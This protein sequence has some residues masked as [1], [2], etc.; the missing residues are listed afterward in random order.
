MGLTAGTKLG[1]YE[2][3]QAVGA[4]GFGQVYKARDT[5]LDRFVAIKVLPEHL[6]QNPTLKA[7][8][9]REAKTLA[10]LSHARICPIFDFG[11]QDGVDY[12]VMEFLE[13][14]TLAERVQRGALPLQEGLKIAID[15]ADAL[16]AAHQAGI[17]HRDLKPGNVM[18][19]KAGPKLLDFGLAKQSAAA[20]FGVQ[21][22][23]PT[24]APA[25]TGE[26]T[27]LG[28]L[29]YMA[30]EQLEG[31]E[32]DGRTDIFAFGAVVYEMLTGKKAFEAKSQVSLIAAILDRDPA[33]I[34]GL[35]PM[36]PAVL[37]HLISG[38]LAKDPADRWQ[39]AHDVL[40]Q[41]KWISEAGASTV[42]GSPNTLGQ[43]RLWITVTAI[44]GV[45]AIVVASL[46][47]AF[48]TAPEMSAARFTVA[49]PEHVKHLMSP[50]GAF[51]GAIS[52]DGR[53]LVFEG[54][55]VDTDKV[56]LYLR[57]IDSIQTMPLQGTE[58]GAYPFW[59][60][61]SHTIAFYAQGKLKRVDLSGGA[62]QIICDAPTGGWGGSWNRDDVILAGLNDPAPIS[63]VSAKGGES[64]LIGSLNSEVDQD[65][66]HF[67]PDGKHFVYAAW[68][69][70]L[71]GVESAQSDN[72]AYVGSLD[73]QDRKLVVKGNTSDVLYADPGYLIFINR[74]RTLVAQPFDAKRLEMT[75]EPIRLAENASG[76]LSVSTN[77]VLTYMTSSTTVP[78]QFVWI[79]RDGTPLGPVLEAGYYAD[80]QISPDGSR[81]AFAKKESASNTFDIWILDLTTG[82]QRRL[83]FDP[84]DDRSPVWSPDG[85]AIIFSSDRKGG[86]GLYRKNSNGVGDEELVSPKEQYS[87]LA[88]QWLPDGRSVIFR[89]GTSAI[90]LW[91]L[92]LTDRKSSP[93]IRTPW[94]NLH[95]VVSPDGK[96]LAYDSRDTN[97]FE[98]YVTTFPP[99]NS[100]WMVTTNGG[101]EP[102]WSKDGKELFYVN[103]SGSL[104]SVEVKVGNPPEFGVHRRIYGGRLDWGF[105]SA[106]SFDIDPKQDRFLVETL[107]VQYEITVVLNWH[108]LLKK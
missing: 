48:R 73:S 4:G 99:T 21:P 25:L 58:G 16:S 93:L 86:V 24:I 46:A 14:Q 92:N 89:G 55:D 78:D 97:R 31:K 26:G 104:M 102:R 66:P 27:I 57:S 6:S 42:Q 33:P 10:S 23:A 36:T 22:D 52:P 15:I 32:A 50:G 91:M 39:T 63:K 80:P 7:R 69:A 51:G 94:N 56:M 1:P 45:A 75:G 106:H 95:G 88:S 35:Q 19:T 101:A 40:K 98:V 71:S 64:V 103:S 76:P 79:R 82:A 41:L 37:D 74:D 107:N 13:G 77:G 87:T 85:A 5:R 62:P 12:L 108:S 2:I 3:I 44:L 47:Y 53:H 17:T 81:L 96:W 70:T 11:Q 20:S 8:F 72:A 90:N 38:C 67:L 83:T 30:P 29:Q 105:E 68:G 65:S 61:D 60:P 34:S 54:A 28:T 84:T 100:K 59:S 49:F 18:L 43:R 9:E